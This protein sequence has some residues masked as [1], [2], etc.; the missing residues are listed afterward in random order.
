[1]Q[2]T[3]LEHKCCCANFAYPLSTYKCKHVQHYAFRFQMKT[4]YEENIEKENTEQ[5]SN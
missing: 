2:G 1:M 3:R 5:A 4:S